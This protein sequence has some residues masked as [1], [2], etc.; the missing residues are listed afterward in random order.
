MR[1][2]GRPRPYKPLA[3]L[4]ALAP[5]RARRGAFLLSSRLPPPGVGGCAVSS[6]APQAHVT[7]SRHSNLRCTLLLRSHRL[8]Q[9]LP[10]SRGAPDSE[11][12]HVD[13]AVPSAAAMADLKTTDLQAIAFH[14]FTRCKTERA[15]FDECMDTENKSSKCSEQYKALNACASSL[16]GDAKSKAAHEFKEYSH[17]LDLTGGRYNYC[18]PE[19]AK[20]EEAFP[21]IA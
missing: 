11:Q 19:K 2:L 21:F 9:F 4:G 13:R 18:R 14:L 17:C 20:F 6:S 15:A 1:D 8:G 7:C 5:A 16:L 3:E 10:L 12:Q